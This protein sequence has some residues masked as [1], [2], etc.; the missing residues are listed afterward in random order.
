RATGSV[1]AIPCVNCLES[2]WTDWQQARVVR[3]WEAAFPR[4]NNPGK[5]KRR[6]FQAL[7]WLTIAGSHRHNLVLDRLGHRGEDA[8]TNTKITARNSGHADPQGALS[9]PDAWIRCR[10]ANNANVRARPQGG[11]RVAVS[12]AVPAGAARIDQV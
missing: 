10:A 1:S 11:G 5:D 9:R 12:G 8:N 4:P 7:I 2:K 3:L 6:L